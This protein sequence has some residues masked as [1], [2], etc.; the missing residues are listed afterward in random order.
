MILNS[1][2][3]T[4]SVGRRWQFPGFARAYR[5]TPG[6][7][8]HGV[9]HRISQFCDVT[10]LACWAAKTETCDQ[11]GSRRDPTTRSSLKEGQNV[12]G[13][14]PGAWNPVPTRFN[15]PPDTL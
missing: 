11:F 7:P 3:S 5:A 6:C 2:S 8:E 13:V 1:C 14:R 12:C 9:W 4:F 15:Q 10:V